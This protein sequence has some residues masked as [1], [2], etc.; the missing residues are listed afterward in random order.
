MSL[1][2]FFTEAFRDLAAVFSLTCSIGCI[3][4]THRLSRIQ[5]AERSIWKKSVYD[6]HNL[7]QGLRDA[8]K[9]LTDKN[10]ELFLENEELKKQI[11]HM[12]D[13]QL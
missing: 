1:D 3:W 5:A 8:C 10:R 6:M 12:S 13:H 11:R 7:C 2:I 4:L 9:A